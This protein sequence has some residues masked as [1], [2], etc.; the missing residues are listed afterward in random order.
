MKSGRHN[1]TSVRDRD[2]CKQQ[3]EELHA[4]EASGFSAGIENE[5]QNLEWCALMIC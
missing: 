4:T 1:F 3:I 5:L 2:Y